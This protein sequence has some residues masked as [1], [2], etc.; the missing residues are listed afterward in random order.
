MN[1]NELRDYHQ[2][3]KA[4]AE[5]VYFS[6]KAAGGWATVF[7]NRLPRW[8]SKVR[9]YFN[10]LPTTLTRLPEQNAKHLLSSKS[11]PHLAFLIQ[12]HEDQTFNRYHRGK[13]T[14]LG[15]APPAFKV[16][17]ACPAKAP[18]DVV[19]MSGRHAI[20]TRDALSG[21]VY[22][23]ELGRAWYQMAA[24]ATVFH[25][26]RRPRWLTIEAIW[27]ELIRGQNDTEVFK[28]ISMDGT[29]GSKEVILAN[30]GANAYGWGQGSKRIG[31]VNETWNIRKIIVTHPAY[32]GS[33][34][35]SETTQMGFAAHQLRDI[36]THREGS[37][38]Y[39]NPKD[40]HSPLRTRR[41]PEKD[42]Q[43]NLLADQISF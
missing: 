6:A 18:H 25:W 28:L 2:W 4:T 5:D 26:G 21:D 27:V 34:N 40:L 43:G 16:S 33:Y 20:S 15:P 36:D 22:L 7:P 38:F 17:P 35:Y 42:N 8:A 41:F 31:G 30:D 24:G 19:H 29:G 10:V 13:P 37:G 11:G 9:N 3:L 39:V 14:P 32:Q 23:D 12:C 1:L